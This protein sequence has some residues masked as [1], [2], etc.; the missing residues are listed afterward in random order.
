T[1]WKSRPL[2]VSDVAPLKDGTLVVAAGG[3]VVEITR[4]DGGIAWEALLPAEAG[5]WAARPCLRLIRLGFDAPRP[6]NL[7]LD[8]SVEY[9]WA[10]LTRRNPVVRRWSAR[11]LGGMGTKGE[12]AVP[13]LIRAL[14]DPDAQ[15]RSEAGGA[16]GQVVSPKT[17]PRLLSAMTTKSPR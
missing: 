3:R 14:D 1:I 11:V 10:G 17:L 6:T 8:A 13:A 12:V 9:R 15:T 4:A 16:L 2:A 5:G 7:D